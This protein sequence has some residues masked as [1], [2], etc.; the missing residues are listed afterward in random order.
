MSIP[1]LTRGLKCRAVNQ[2]EHDRVRQFLA[3]EIRG[4]GHPEVVQVELSSH[5]FLDVERLW[6]RE[7]QV[8]GFI[9]LDNATLPEL[10]TLSVTVR[11]GIARSRCLPTNQGTGR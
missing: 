6:D 4:T 1:I 3:I 2:I 7:D 11:G 8:A 10:Y 9:D 5:A